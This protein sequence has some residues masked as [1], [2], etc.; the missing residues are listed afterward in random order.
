MKVELPRS[1]VLGTRVNASSFEESVKLLEGFVERREPARFSA[2]TVYSVMLGREDSGFREIVNG[3]D[4]VM[5][6]GMPLVWALR[7]TGLAAERVHGDDFFL[8]VCRRHPEWRHY[9]IGGGA[10][11]PEVARRVLEARFPG[12]RVVGTHATPVRPVPPAENERILTDIRR[13]EPDVVWVGMGTP[14]QDRWMAELGVRV[15]RPTVGVGSAFDLLTGVKRPTPEW[16]KRSGLQWLHRLWQ[17]PR[18]LAYRYLVY[19]PLFLWCWLTG[20]RGGPGPR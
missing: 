17:E 12:M 20:R 19:N 9:L 4:Y 1:D 6:D 13:A 10:G 14:A 15:G 18:R 5:A 8:E 16:M 11:Q 3:A 2:A 7:R